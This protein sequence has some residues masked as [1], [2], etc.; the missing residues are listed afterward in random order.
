MIVANAIKPMPRMDDIDRSKCLRAIFDART[1]AEQRLW[2]GNNLRL[3]KVKTTVELHPAHR[4]AY[5]EKTLNLKNIATDNFRWNTE[6]AIFTFRLPE[7]GVVTSSS[8]WI[9]GEERPAFLTTRGKADSAYRAVVGVERRDPSV[10]HWQEGN[11]V[12]VRVFPCTPTLPRQFKLGF[13]TPL[14]KKGDQLI[15]ENITFDGVIADDVKDSLRF[16]FAE[17]PFYRQLCGFRIR[18]QLITNNC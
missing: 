12:T 8:L 6:E 10:V 14:R 1:Q 11:A 3:E 5:I 17:L 18:S 16:H 7:G 2:S 15:Y 9:D 13:T 4:L